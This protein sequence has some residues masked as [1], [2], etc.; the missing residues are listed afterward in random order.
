V[1][2]R[3]GAQTHPIALPERPAV[4]THRVSYREERHVRNWLCVVHTQLL[5]VCDDNQ[6]DRISQEEFLKFLVRIV[7][8]SVWIVYG[9]HTC[10]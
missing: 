3:E 1:P 9:T 4:A 2:Y 10:L 7:F 8:G 5:R 6:D